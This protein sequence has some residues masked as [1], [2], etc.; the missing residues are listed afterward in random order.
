VGAALMGVVV[1]KLFLVDLSN[2]GTVERIVSFIGVG[3]LMLVI[4]YLS[5]VPPRLRMENPK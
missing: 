2:V 4:G 3:V 5:P 1:V